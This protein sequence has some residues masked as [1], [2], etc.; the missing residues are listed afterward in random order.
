MKKT[1]NYLPYVVAL[2]PQFVFNNYNLI[3]ISTI[4]IGFIAQFVID[5]NK[6]FFK[7]FIL[8]I[9]AFS[10]VF[11]LLKER[12]YY[13]N[14]ALNNLGFS[15]ILIVILLPVFNAINISILFFFGYKLSNLIFLK[16]R[17]KEF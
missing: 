17:S 10:I 6:V 11:F 8:E 14:E 16:M 7:V 2:I 12:V 1:L 13:L 15:E 5:R 3:L 4:L 9:L